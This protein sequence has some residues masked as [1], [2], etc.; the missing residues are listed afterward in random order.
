M[1]PLETL[2]YRDA[3]SAAAEITPADI[4]PLQLHARRDRSLRRRCRAA[5][6]AAFTGAAPS[7]GGRRWLVPLA[8]AISVAALL[9]V[10]VAVRPG[11]NAGHRVAGL[12]SPSISLSR[13]QARLAGEALNSY[14][15]ATGAQ[16]TAGLAF[17]WTQQ[18]IQYRLL[19]PC[20]AYAGFPQPAFS[21]SKPDYLLSFPDNSQFPDLTQRARTRLMTPGPGTGDDPSG[22]ESNGSSAETAAVRRCTASHAQLITR[23]DRASGPLASAWLPIISRVQ[24]SAPVRAM[25]PAFNR[26]LEA[27]GIPVTYAYGNGNSL[28]EGFFR[29]MDHLGM[30]GTSNREHIVQQH[31]WTPVFVQ[32][33]RPTVTVMERLQLAQRARFLRRHVRQIN[34]IKALA[35]HLLSGR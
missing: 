26:C 30:T 24:S 27:H 6:L 35:I 16:Y 17:E 12:A 13:G 3:A 15:P 8:A 14:F 20:L 7:A 31:R 4:P 11:Q 29:W 19:E 33:A 22:L 5:A 9:A 34:V 28:F 23:L 21:W 10:L 1:N 25:Q 18:K 32:C 2:I